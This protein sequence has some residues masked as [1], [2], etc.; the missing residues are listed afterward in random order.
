MG[1][2][3]AAYLDAREQQVPSVTA[4]ALLFFVSFFNGAGVH[5][6]ATKVVD[7]LVP[8][9]SFITAIIILMLVMT[10]TYNFLLNGE[11]LTVRQWVGLGLALLTVFVLVG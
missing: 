4:I 9:V 1:G 5:F 10:P 3:G 2:V 6:Q 8:T 11:G 7:P